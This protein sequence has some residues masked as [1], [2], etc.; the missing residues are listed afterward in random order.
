MW[1][2]ILDHQEFF[3]KSQFIGFFKGTYTWTKEHMYQIYGSGCW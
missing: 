1:N 2:N 3:E